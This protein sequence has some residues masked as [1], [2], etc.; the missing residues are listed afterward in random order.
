MSA[1]TRVEVLLRRVGFDFYRTLDRFY[2][3]EDRRRFR[4]ARNIRLIPS[5]R[6]RR[7]GKRAYAEWAHVIGIFQS[8]MFL[9]LEKKEGNVV[10]D[11][12]CGTGLLGIASEPFIGQGGKYIGLAV[13]MGDVEFCRG[14][15]SPESYEFVHFDMKNPAYAP[16]QKSEISSWPVE[17][18]GVDLV[19]A[20]SVWTHLD[21]DDSL[22]YLEEVS[23]VL[24]PGGKAIITFFVLDEAYR[25][26][27]EKR[28]DREGR[29]HATSQNRWIF[30]QPAYGSND[31]LYPSWAK[32]PEAAIGVT[33]AGLD[34]LLSSS[35]L[36]LI[37]K[38]PGN[39][40][41]A[42]GMYFQDTL[43]FEKD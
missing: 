5:E 10:L 26:S 20:L 42:P 41:E 30:D 21:A 7:G 33:E 2:L 17:A 1:R 36:R 13:A 35:G 19:T 11:V 38:Y 9:H 27:L 23:R 22:F 39:W 31:W 4:R 3:S 6:D 29:F 34:R 12:G 24:R 14:H 37:E 18:G 40:K 25:E 43:I 28:S 32:V 15:Y 8:L 16:G